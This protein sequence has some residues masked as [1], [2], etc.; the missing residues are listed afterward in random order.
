LDWIGLDVWKKFKKISWQ[1]NQDSAMAPKRLN[2]GEPENSPDP[3]R[4]ASSKKSHIIFNEDGSEVL[5][6]IKSKKP[7]TN[8]KKSGDIEEITQTQSQ[9]SLD[10]LLLEENELSF[11][12]YE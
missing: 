4:K 5:V 11:K 7:K 12:P 1:T 8:K 10:V 3:K 2:N 6:K 9:E